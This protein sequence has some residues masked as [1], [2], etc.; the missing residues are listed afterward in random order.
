MES[1]N[2]YKNKT[3][4]GVK[5]SNWGCHSQNRR[6]SDRNKCWDNSGTKSVVP[7]FNSHKTG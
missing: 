2:F 7:D 5:T 3:K 1:F 4:R 6:C